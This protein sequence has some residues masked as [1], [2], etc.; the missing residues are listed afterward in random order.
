MH[1]QKSFGTHDGRPEFA[2][3]DRKNHYN[4]QEGQT[5]PQLTFGSHTGPQHLPLLQPDAPMMYQRLHYGLEGWSVYRQLPQLLKYDQA[6]K[7]FLTNCA[8]GT[9][10]MPGYHK[11]QN[12]PSLWTYYKTLPQWCRDNQ[13]IRQTLFAFEYHK[14]HLDIRQKELAM[15]FV[16]SML[17][18]LEGRYKTVVTEV[19]MSNKL[20][21]TMQNGKEMMSELNFYTIDLADLGSDTED[22]GDDDAEEKEFARLLMGGLDDDESPENMSTMQKVMKEMEGKSLED[23][24]REIY[25]NELTTNEFELDPETQTC[26][27]DFP[28]KPYATV[29]EVQAADEMANENLVPINYYDNDDGFWDDYI[30]MKLEKWD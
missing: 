30:D 25:D 21:V 5:N 17:R 11:E 27:V 20:R 24:R 6:M 2:M 28:T 15:N 26:M 29:D 9:A 12:Q 16:A 22:D 14:P 18:P 7:D 19:A 23:D 10:I 3:F 13:L 1:L 8:K 4:R